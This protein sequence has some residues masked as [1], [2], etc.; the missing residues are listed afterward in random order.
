MSAFVIGARATPEKVRIYNELRSIFQGLY[1]S[2][3]AM[4]RLKE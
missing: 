1:E 4:S 2:N 3:L